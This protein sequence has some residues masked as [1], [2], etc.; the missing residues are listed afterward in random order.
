MHKLA[1]TLRATGSVRSLIVHGDGDL[2][3]LTTT[4]PSWVVSLND[5]EI[6]EAE[7]DATDFGL[8][9][10]APGALAGGDP[11]TNAEIADRIFAGERG[12]ARDIVVL[13]AAAA[14]VTA[15]VVDNLGA[16][17]EAAAA[18]IDDGRAAAKLEALRS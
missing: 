18:A 9:R 7:I 1:E 14:L 10:V 12:A 17:V 6:T 15:A 5:G 11:A 16:G 4:G 3:E 13:N 8:A 2:D